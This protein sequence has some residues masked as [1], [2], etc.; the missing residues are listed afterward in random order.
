MPE[1]VKSL[2][3]FSFGGVGVAL[4]QKSP[5]EVIANPCPGMP[6]Y[7]LQGCRVTLC[8]LEH[9]EEGNLSLPKVTLK[10][11]SVLLCTACNVMQSRQQHV[12][13]LLL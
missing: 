2:A 3:L 4:P 7:P 6:Q 5:A 8:F 1:K 13:S 10:N 9:M 12:L 11:I